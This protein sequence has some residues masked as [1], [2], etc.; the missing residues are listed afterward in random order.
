MSLRQRS[1][2]RSVKEYAKTTL[3]GAYELL[4][5]LKESSGVCPPLKSATS[6]IVACIEVY[7]VCPVAPST[8]I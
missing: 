1:N 7:K 6:G 2:S 4:K 3:K 8:L 5:V